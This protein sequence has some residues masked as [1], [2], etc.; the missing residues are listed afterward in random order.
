MSDDK[1]FR[2]G[3]GHRAIDRRV[4]K[5]AWAHMTTPE[6]VKHMN[7]VAAEITRLRERVTELRVLK[8]C[9]GEQLDDGEAGF[10]RSCSGCYETS[11]GYN[12]NGYPYSDIFRCVLG[13]GCFECG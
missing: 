8:T 7:N 1:P 13:G 9:V 11:D 4:A 3:C 10:W 12:V 2:E 6:T 5:T